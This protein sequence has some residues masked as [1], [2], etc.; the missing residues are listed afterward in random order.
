MNY[1][2]AHVLDAA[3]PW[4]LYSKLLKEG[5]IGITME[6]IKGDTRSLDYS[7]CQAG[8]HNVFLGIHSQPSIIFQDFQLLHT[9]RMHGSK[10]C[11][12][13]TRCLASQ[14]SRHMQDICLNDSTCKRHG[15]KT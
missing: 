9:S 2:T 14:K 13:H 12:A 4:E 5:Y 15:L 8:Q 11:G 10:L 7:S 1:K 6:L 3:H